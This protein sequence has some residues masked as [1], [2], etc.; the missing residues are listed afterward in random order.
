M[1]LDGNS[2]SSIAFSILSLSG[3]GV[4]RAHVGSSQLPNTGQSESTALT[5]QVD[6]SFP[7]GS[8]TMVAEII[9]ED[10]G[11]AEPGMPMQCNIETVV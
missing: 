4:E 3:S 8:C 5:R 7:P 2:K 1:G 9:P 10:R 11:R 6:T